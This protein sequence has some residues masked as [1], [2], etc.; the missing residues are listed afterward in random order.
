MTTAEAIEAC[1]VDLGRAAAIVR[2]CTRRLSAVNGTT[3]LPA[4]FADHQGDL[5]SAHGTLLRVADEM[6][7]SQRKAVA[8]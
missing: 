6:G 7:A 4:G 1:E 5:Y 2:D 3:P 8:S